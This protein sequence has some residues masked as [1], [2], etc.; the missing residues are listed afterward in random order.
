MW[1][2]CGSAVTFDD[3]HASRSMISLWPW[4]VC[5]VQLFQPVKIVRDAQTDGPSLKQKMAVGL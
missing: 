2:H 3:P 1:L 5:A 4:D